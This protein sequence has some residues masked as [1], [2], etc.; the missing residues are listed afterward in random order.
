MEDAATAKRDARRAARERRR[1]LVAVRD[2]AADGEALARWVVPL[3]ALHAGGRARVALYEAY[4]VEPPTSAL[5]AAL[6]AAGHEVV[7]PRM[8][9]DRSLEWVT[10]GGEEL[11]ADGISLASVVLT[12]GLAVDRAGVRL[13]QGGG[14]YDRALRRRRRDALVLTLLHDGEVRPVGTLPAE[15]HDEPVDGV[16]TPAAGFL[17]L[18]PPPGLTPEQLLRW[19]RSR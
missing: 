17:D 7:L 8:L 2:L 1:E 14:S 5:V 15:E 9:A 4:G 12:P 3:V 16:V 11:G 10:V 6:G 13:G 18:R 19:R